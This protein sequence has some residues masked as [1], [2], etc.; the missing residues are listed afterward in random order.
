LSFEIFNIEIH[1]NFFKFIFQFLLIKT[2]KLCCC[3]AGSGDS[4]SAASS[5][6]RRKSAICDMREK[7]IKTE[8]EWR[9]EKWMDRLSLKSMNFL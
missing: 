7:M 4:A 1:L 5:I 9:M 3:C 6:H 2:N 8:L